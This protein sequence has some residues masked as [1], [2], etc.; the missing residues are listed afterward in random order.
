MNRKNLSP[1]TRLIGDDTP[2]P[3]TQRPIVAPIH[4]TTT[5]RIDDAL[6]AAML[7]GDYRSE[8]LYTRMGNP[9]VRALEERLAELHLAEDA[10][11]AASG[12]GALSALLFGR[13]DPGDRILAGHALYGVTDSLLDRYLTPA[14]RTVERFDVADPDALAHAL[15][16]GPAAL[17]LIETL[18]NPLVFCPDL[19]A[20]SAICGRHDVPLAVDNTFAN[21]IGCRPR[22]HGATWVVESLSKSI[23]GHSDVH[24]GVVCGPREGMSSV[25]EAMLHFGACLDPHAASMIR[26]GMKTLAMRTETMSENLRRV[27]ERLETHPEIVTVHAPGHG[28]PLPPWIDHPGGMLA[29]VVRGGDERALRLL[30]RL[31]VIEP[32]TSLG[33]VESLASLPFNTSH[34][35]PASR[36]RIGLQPGTVRLSVGCEHP[37]DLIADLLGALDAS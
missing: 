21:P 19:P 30:D 2:A 4:Q 34:R 22:A 13:T 17:V 25:W 35:H 37:D 20:L 18:T 16:R 26:R 1:R 8:F 6:N 5:F 31:R 12:M 7:A 32:A 24:G 29:F 27:A 15:D 33:G 23:A 3:C 10:V 36:E 11:C 28:A 14:G 9:T